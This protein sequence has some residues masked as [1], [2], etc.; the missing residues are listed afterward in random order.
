MLSKLPPPLV[1]PPHQTSRVNIEPP[2]PGLDEPPPIR[3]GVPQWVFDFN[4]T[5]MAS[6]GT[7]VLI[8]EGTTKRPMFA[9]HG[10]EGWYWVPSPEHNQCY[11]VCVPSTHMERIVRTVDLF[12]CNFPVPKRLSTYTAFQAVEDLV[13]TLNNPAPASLF[14]VGDEEIQ[15]IKTLQ[16]ILAIYLPTISPTT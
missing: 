11:T 1:V 13:E 15:A 3:R 7:R 9:Q 10:V 8:F 4:C 5:P 12:R 2:T 6:P 14:A 16:G